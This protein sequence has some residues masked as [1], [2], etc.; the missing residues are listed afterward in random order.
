[1]NNKDL[2][3]NRKRGNQF[4][5]TQPSTEA[6]P[7][8][9]EKKKVEGNVSLKVSP[10]TRAMLNA[11]KDFKSAKNMDELLSE[12]VEKELQALEPEE[13]KAI[14]IIAKSKR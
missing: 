5:P 2:L 14:E 13:K 7:I 3:A 9:P 6:T 1:M 11:I 12:L 10:T 4:E 8:K